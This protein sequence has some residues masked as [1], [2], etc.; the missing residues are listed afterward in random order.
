MTAAY[1]QK[2]TDFKFYP[3]GSAVPLQFPDWL[4][5]ALL[6]DSEVRHFWSRYWSEN[7]TGGRAHFFELMANYL[8]IRLCDTKDL[9]LRSEKLRTR[10]VILSQAE[11][12]SW[13]AMGK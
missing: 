6:T 8:L 4:N 5:N 10:P 9:L 2:P 12:D 13:N 7:P 11:I 1:V 3:P